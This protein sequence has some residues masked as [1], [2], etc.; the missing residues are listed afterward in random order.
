LPIKFKDSIIMLRIAVS[1]R[2]LFNFEAENNVFEQPE[3]ISDTEHLAYK[4]LQ[5]EKINTPALPGVAFRLVKKLLSLNLPHRQLCEVIIV[6]RNDPVSGLRVFRSAQAAQLNIT[7]AVFTGGNNPYP[8]LVPFKAT[9]FLSANADDVRGALVAG[10]AAAQVYVSSISDTEQHTSEIRIA[11]DGDAVLFSDEAENIYQSHGLAA[12]EAHE[13]ANATKALPA[14]P[15]KPLLE[16]LQILQAIPD[17][18][19]KIRTALVTA[20]SAPAHER[21]IRTLMAWNIAVDEAMF[22]G[23]L[24]KTD[25]LKVFAPDFFFDD[26]AQHCQLASQVTPTAQ[27]LSRT[28]LT[29]KTT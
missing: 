24:N 20:R 18:P 15:F 4:H 28:H 1:S 27:V 5:L 11:F 17:L 29:L 10:F 22:L 13:S 6:S 16:A 25:F 3:Y 26:Q 14:G 8:Y 19:I 2:A 9:L 7:R 23:G 21:A 12:F